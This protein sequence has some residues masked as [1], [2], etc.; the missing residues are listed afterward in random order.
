MAVNP[1]GKDS[2]QLI[3]ELLQEYGLEVE[4]GKNVKGSKVQ[5]GGFPLSNMSTKQACEWLTNRT[6]VG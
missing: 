6:R 3:K 1:Y 5:N 4:V 2:V